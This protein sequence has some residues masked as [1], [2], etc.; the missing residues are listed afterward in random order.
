MITM[1]DLKKEYLS[2]KEEIDKAIKDVF[3][4]GLFILGKQV[5]SFEK[6]FASYLGV[7]H[8]IGVGSGTEAI[9]LALVAHGIKQ[10]DEVITVPNTAVP[11]VSAI[12]F[13]GATPVFVDIDPDS[14]GMD[15]TKLE[16][17][18]TKKTNAIVP[19]HLFGHAADM[20]PLMEISKKH[21]LIVVEDAC[22]A[23]GALYKNK[24]V[25][26]IGNAGAFSFYPTKNLGAYGDAGMVVTND[27]EIADRIKYLRNYGETEKR[28]SHKIRGFNSRLDEI[29]AAILRAKLKHLDKWNNQR[30]NLASEYSSMLSGSSVKTA[31]EKEYSKS[32][33]HL[34]V[35]RTKK[36]DE[37]KKFLRDNE[38][39]TNIHYP[40]PIY[41]QEAYRYLGIKKS[42][43][44]VAEKY[45]ERILSL[46]LYPQ[47]P[48]E[49][50]E[51]V[52]KL[53]LGF[54]KK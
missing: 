29:Q 16:K 20:D 8:A 35:I 14:H 53:I 11:T 25:G 24:K 17:K 41:M 22:Q 4:S 32:C 36:R 43:C 28:Y 5:E 13:A 47:M 26:T 23:H 7:K 31:K 33:H 9:H 38:V 27:K 50:V 30:K 2:I 12:D 52:S 1:V 42:E 19:V 37:L 39:I 18:I 15:I 51:K 54:E 40:I 48:E 44:P 34:Y 21:N 46:P 45:A 3:N 10:G 49:D 6:E